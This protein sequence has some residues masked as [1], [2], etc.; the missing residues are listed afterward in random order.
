MSASTL[1]IELSKGNLFYP[2]RTSTDQ[3]GAA[4]SLPSRPQPV[5]RGFT[6]NN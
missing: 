4:F 1:W 6:I 3:C 2:V 5:T